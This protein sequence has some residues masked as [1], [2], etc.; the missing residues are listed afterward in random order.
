MQND[1]KPIKPRRALEVNRRGRGK[2]GARQAGGLV[3]LQGPTTKAK[4]GNEVPA[5]RTYE[6]LLG[7]YAKQHFVPMPAGRFPEGDF[8]LTLHRLIARWPAAR[9]P[10]RRA[11]ENPGDVQVRQRSLQIRSR[12]QRVPEATYE[13]RRDAAPGAASECTDPACR[14]LAG[15]G[16]WH[17]FDADW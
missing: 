12:P 10:S 16:S 17:R 11:L 4:R 13:S 6:Q 5:R 2:D 14:R 15:T 3:S 1:E 9:E 7:M 8:L